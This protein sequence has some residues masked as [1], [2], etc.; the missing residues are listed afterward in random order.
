MGSSSF[1]LHPQLEQASICVEHL[2]LSEVRLHKNAAWPW[3]VLVPHIAEPKQELVDLSYD[4]SCRVHQE[5][6]IVSTALR[7]LFKPDKLNMGILGNKVPQLHIHLLAR[8]TVDPAWPEPVWGHS[9]YKEYTAD[10]LSQRVSD[11][12]EVLKH[13]KM[14]LRL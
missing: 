2:F 1:A 8:Y 7:Y 5:I 4:D 13:Y 10:A 12:A 14:N 11:L 9:A 6:R 3:V